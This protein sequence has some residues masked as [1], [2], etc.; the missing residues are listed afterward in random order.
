VNYKNI[1]GLVRTLAEKQVSVGCVM[2]ALKMFERLGMDEDGVECLA[3]ADRNKEAK[4]KC[5][6]LSDFHTNP[7]M[8]CMYGDLC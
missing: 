1:F 3:M 7:K 2:S 8:L 5:R 6:S 4:E